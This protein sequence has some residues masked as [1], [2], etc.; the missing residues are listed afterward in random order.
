MYIILSRLR[1]TID[2][3]IVQARAHATEA[4]PE[5]KPAG[6]GDRDGGKRSRA[7]AA[8]TAQLRAP[9]PMADTPEKQALERAPRQP[10]PIILM[11]TFLDLYLTKF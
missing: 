9:L 7:A 3:L 10:S 8:A 6:G 2:G 11:N 1:C 4:V 5:G